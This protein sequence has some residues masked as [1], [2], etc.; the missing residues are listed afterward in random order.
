MMLKL[1][2]LISIKHYASQCGIKPNAVYRRLATGSI[3]RV[4]IGGVK[5][6]DISIHPPV[7][8]NPK[9]QRSPGHPY[10]VTSAINAEGDTITLAHLILSRE[11]ARKVRVSTATVH[12][13]IIL[14]EVNAVIIDDEIFIDTEENPPAE[15]RPNR[16]PPRSWA[17]IHGKGAV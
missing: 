12:H 3:K 1:E 6:I 2:N 14:K 9:G 10:D 8:R 5:F 7:Y 15:F 13:R 17:E 16:K 4:V 11:Y